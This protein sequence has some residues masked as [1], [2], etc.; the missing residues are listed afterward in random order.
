MAEEF[1][2]YCWIC[3]KPVRLKDC[4]T[5]DRGRP[6]HEDCY[7]AIAMRDEYKEASGF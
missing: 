3:N 1:V 5:D 7:V 4:K 6:V 2:V